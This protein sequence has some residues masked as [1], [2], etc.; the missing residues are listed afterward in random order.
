[1][2]VLTTAGR[3]TKSC[4]LRYTAGGTAIANFSVATDVGFGDKK[5]AV[6]IGCSLFGKRAEALSEYL[7]KGTSVTVSGEADLRLWESNG[8]HGAEITMNVQ[9][10]ALQ[11]G[12]QGGSKPA[13]K[14]AEKQHQF[15][16]PEANKGTDWDDSDQIPF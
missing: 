7:L 14:P 13:Q 8:N 16:D 1:M 3:L 11:G 10:V 15:R 4:V 5:H 2:N 9:D 12:K 6:F